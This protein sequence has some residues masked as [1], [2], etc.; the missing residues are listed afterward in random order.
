[1]NGGSA[2]RL[3]GCVGI[4]VLSVGALID[5]GVIGAQGLSAGEELV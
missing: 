4:L 5:V 3:F 2:C 1:M